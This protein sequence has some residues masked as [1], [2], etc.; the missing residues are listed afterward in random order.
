MWY[1]LLVV[2]ILIL[3]FR[4]IMVERAIEQLTFQLDNLYNEKT[5]AK[6]NV[7]FVSRRLIK[8]ATLINI[9]ISKH[10]QTQIVNKRREDNLKTSISAISHDLRTPLTSIMGYLQLIKNDSSKTAEYLNTIEH[11]AKSLGVLINDFYEMSCFDDDS[12]NPPLS[13]IDV[14]AVLSECLAG[15]YSLFEE[16]GITPRI[17]IPDRAVYII[18]NVTVYERIFQ[19]LIGNALKFSDDISI[20]LSSNENE[21]VFTIKNPAVLLTQQDIKHIFDRF[22]TADKS[23]KKGSGLG[24]YI[25]KTL[26][27]HMNADVSAEFIDG[28]FTVTLKQAIG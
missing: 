27:Q 18:G 28:M 23:R 17:I 11:R 25:V 13:R 15:C 9:G 8:L 14:V 21:M 1:I 3:L 7:T 24:L 10:E 6:L 22:Y 12:Y 2:I 4:L 20:T 16:K 5:R 19:N 26:S